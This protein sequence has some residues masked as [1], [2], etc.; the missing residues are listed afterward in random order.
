MRI[1]PIIIITTIILFGCN[2][3]SKNTDTLIENSES[4]FSIEENWNIKI[5]KMYQSDFVLIDPNEKG[6]LIQEFRFNK[7][8]YVNELIRY[9]IDG[10]IISRFDIYGEHTPF[11]LPGKPEFMDTVLTVF[12]FNTSGMVSGKE[13]KI[14]NETGLLIQVDFFEGEDSLVKRNTYNY[15]KNNMIKEDVYWD[16]E[17]DKPKQKI[18][19]E[20]E[21]FID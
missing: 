14:Y 4:S 2:Q 7:E 10:E 1:N 9:G 17:L 8:G 15:D 6:Q 13:V 19:Y 18:R 21:Y 3:N 11:P 12:N 5:C 20:F 16:V